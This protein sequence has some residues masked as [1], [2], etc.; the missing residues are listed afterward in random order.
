[1]P[2]RQQ[3][4]ALNRAKKV[5]DESFQSFVT[6]FIILMV[7]VFMIREVTGVLLKKR[8]AGYFRN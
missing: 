3:K 4:S 8:K 7:K 2:S 6:K 1:M 5:F